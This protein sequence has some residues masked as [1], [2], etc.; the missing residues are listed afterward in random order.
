MS[1]PFRWNPFKR[2]RHVAKVAAQAP[3]PKNPAGEVAGGPAAP[4]DEHRG[5]AAVDAEDPDERRVRFF[6]WLLD[7]P[8]PLHT[9]SAPASVIPYMLEQLDRVIASE[10]LRAGLLPRTSCR[11]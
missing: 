2:R 1:L 5:T 6:C 11:S 8:A 10:S 3:A 4:S 7:A 9:G